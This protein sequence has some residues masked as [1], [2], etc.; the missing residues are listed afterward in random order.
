MKPKCVWCSGR[1]KVPMMSSESK[2][3]REVP[4]SLCNGTG[5]VPIV[6]WIGQKIGS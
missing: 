4:C 1:G 3:I 5:R 6:T 2:V